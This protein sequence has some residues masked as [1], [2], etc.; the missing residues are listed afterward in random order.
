MA[1]NFLPIKIKMKKRFLSA[2]DKI[3]INIDSSA[4]EH[5]NKGLYPIRLNNSTTNALLVNKK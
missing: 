4:E 1:L 5:F 2:S 3:Y